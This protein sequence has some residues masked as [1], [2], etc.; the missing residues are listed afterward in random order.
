MTILREYTTCKTALSPSRLPGLDYALNP[1]SG[2]EH[3][4]LYCY[5][6][7]MLRDNSM[8]D[9]WGSFVKAKRNIAERLSREL[10]RVSRG[11]V[12][13]STVTDPYQPYESDLQLTRRCL[14]LLS[15]HR[16]PV[17]IQTKSSLVLRD[18]DLIQRGRFDVGLTITTLDD[19][20]AKSLEPKAS[21]PEARVQA[22]E[23]LAEIG[24]DT[25]LFLGPI[26]PYVNDGED[27]LREIVTIAKHTGSLLLFDLL[28]LK[29]GVLRSLTPFLEHKAPDLSKKLPNLLGLKSKYRER[30]SAAIQNICRE[31]DVKCEPAFSGKINAV[32][33]EASPLGYVSQ[34]LLSPVDRYSR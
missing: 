33:P 25:W 21:P 14:E 26:I 19:N 17:S 31:L 5:S 20:L 24:V 13:V 29:P 7:S 6:R 12:G 16:F 8:T 22:L 34:T 2:C 23:E 32:E 9:R 4:C 27:S 15:A 28:N 18:I 10:R 30:K 3:G 11:I 1:Y